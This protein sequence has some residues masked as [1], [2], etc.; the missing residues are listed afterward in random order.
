MDSPPNLDESTVSF[1]QYTRKAFLLPTTVCA[2]QLR[3]LKLHQL[4][5]HMGQ[6]HQPDRRT[7]PK[8]G[9]KSA[10]MTVYCHSAL[11]SNDSAK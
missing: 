6:S 9:A 8:S 2:R 4:K 1:C 10:L 7:A 11:S 5:L 3:Q